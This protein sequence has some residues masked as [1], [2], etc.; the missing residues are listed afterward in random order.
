[1]PNTMK[2]LMKWVSIVA[3]LL[4]PAAANATFEHRS[5]LS[6]D[7][8]APILDVAAYPENDV[9]L[10]LTPGE[11][12]VYSSGEQAILD[13]IAVDKAFD[14]IAYQEADQMV[15]TA[16]KTSRISIVQFSR[17]YDIDLT[18]RAVKG[19]PDAKVTLVVF[20]DYQ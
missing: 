3:I 20:D 14:R 8:G 17:I 9:L 11:V 4:A 6:A 12:V 5:V 16:S 13:R 19:P 10:I 1:M 7:I 2:W 15:L 18:G